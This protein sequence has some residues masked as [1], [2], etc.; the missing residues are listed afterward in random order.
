MHRVKIFKGLESDVAAVERQMNDWLEQ[1]NAK[2][3]HLTGNIAPQ[4]P[5]D[6]GDQVLGQGRTPSD[7]MIVV[8]YEPE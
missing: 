7:V 4:S 5:D 6:D 8:V 2:I 1:S 3:V